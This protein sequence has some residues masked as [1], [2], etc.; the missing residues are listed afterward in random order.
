[1]HRSLLAFVCVAAA[2]CGG[3]VATTDTTSD[4]APVAAESQSFD[5]TGLLS[6]VSVHDV[7]GVRLIH[8]QVPG[9]PIVR[10]VALLDRG[11]ADWTVEAGGS[12]LALA[13]AAAGDGGPASVGRTAY[14]ETLD[15]LGASIGGGTDYDRSTFAME[16]VR[17]YWPETFALWSE[18]L[19]D[20]GFAEADVERVRERLLTGLR[21]RLDDPDSA[22]VLAGRAA[23]Y[24]QH[25]YAADPSGTEGGL[26]S[27]DEAALRDALA[28]ATARDR[29]T[30]VAVGDV[31]S[32]DL[33][34][35][36]REGLSCLPA[37]SSPAAPAVPP[38]GEA[39]GT[40]DVVLI[41]R[42]GLPT[43]Y[44]LGYFPTPPV[45][46]PDFPALEVALSILDH[47]LFEEVRTKRN[48]SYA[49]AAGMATRAA[50]SGYVYVTA[51][52]PAQTLEVMFATLDAMIAEPVSEQDLHDQIASYLTGYY[53]AL[54][55]N[56]AQAGL[57]AMWDDVGGGLSRATDHIERL[58][59]VTPA[60]V[61]RVLDTWVRD[62][63]FG[64]VGSTEAA[65]AA[66]AYTRR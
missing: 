28:D 32:D 12:A 5:A 19:C 27:L 49:V 46:D 41:E 37:T 47:R 17:S 1:M 58:R 45:S 64:V 52:D 42:A 14:R 13:L 53:I 35:A 56:A 65:D 44:I 8:K 10:I 25:P 57:L 50:N 48:L 60:D 33:V 9:N 30:L 31:A 11:S 21:T 15:R 2:G 18:T 29:I 7:D 4:A 22:V 39:A 16:S 26:L 36:L 6:G 38:L 20:P 3:A 23:R 61:S 51:A 59:A 24:A 54:Q 66:R 63:R 43:N 40:E 55:S 34:A 62:V